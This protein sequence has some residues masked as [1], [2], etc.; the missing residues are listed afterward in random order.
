M[1]RN[2]TGC[3]EGVLYC[4]DKLD[5]FSDDQKR[6]VEQDL[7]FCASVLQSISDAVIATDMQY[8]ILSWNKAA[9][10][11]YGWTQEEVLGKSASDIFWY[12]FPHNPPNEWKEHLQ[13]RG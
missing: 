11:L 5:A 2:T 13:T 12:E 9:E 7:L 3:Y 4:M 10:T 8:T 1:N 6:G